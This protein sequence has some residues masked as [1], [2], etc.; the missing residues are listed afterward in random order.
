VMRIETHIPKNK[1]SK[2]QVPIRYL[3]L[4]ITT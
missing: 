1:V 4:K 3:T 2:T